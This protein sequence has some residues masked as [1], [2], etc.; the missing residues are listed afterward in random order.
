MLD[1]VRSDHLAVQLALVLADFV[2]AVANS[3]HSVLFH[4]VIINTEELLRRERCRVRVP[5]F[6]LVHVI[7][8]MAIHAA[9]PRK[10]HH[11]IRELVETLEALNAFR[12]SLVRMADLDRDTVAVPEERVRDV[13]REVHR[14][15]PVRFPV[16][17]V[18]LMENVVES[19]VEILEVLVSSERLLMEVYVLFNLIVCQPVSEL[20]RVAV[21][22]L[23]ELVRDPI[24]LCVA[25]VVAPICR[26]I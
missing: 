12:D 8:R 25:H 21:E 11:Q 19:L 4:R 2:F 13:F 24:G 14:K 9:V 7:P 18:G 20:G 10:L 23:R 15:A 22:R 6:V 1:D 17:L 16:I 3:K 5:I 26:R